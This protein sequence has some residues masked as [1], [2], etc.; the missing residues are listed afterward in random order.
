MA[1]E[2]FFRIG[3]MYTKSKMKSSQALRLRRFKSF[4]GV[5]PEVCSLVWE[6]IKDVVPSN[7]KPKYLL[8]CLYFMKQYSTEHVRRSLFK[9]DEKTIR[10]WTW[11]IL[12]PIANLNVV[13]LIF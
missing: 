13:I 8:W 5:T 1:A 2:Y 11:I 6:K 10:K 12:K 3:N 9:A 7:S 4:F